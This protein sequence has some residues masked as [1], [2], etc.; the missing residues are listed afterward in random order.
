[1]KIFYPRLR[2]LP[3][4]RAWIGRVDLARRAFS[5][6]A[7]RAVHR[8]RSEGAK[9]LLA[10]LRPSFARPEGDGVC[11]NVRR[12][13][14]L[15]TE[16]RPLRLPFFPKPLVSIVIVIQG[17]G[18]TA[19]ACIEGIANHSAGIPIE[20][21][22]VCD[23]P[24]ESVFSALSL[25]EHLILLGNE[26]GSNYNSSRNR[27]MTAASGDYILFLH[28][29]C[30]AT[31]GWLKSLLEAFDAF[32]NVGA[33]GAKFVSPQGLLQQAG[34]TLGAD[35]T[36]TDLGQ[37][38][39][40][41]R[42]EFNYVKDVDYCS[43]ACILFPRPLL[44]AIGGF[45]EGYASAAEADKDICLAV[46]AQGRRVIY[47]P[48]AEVFH[49]QSTW[50]D[51]PPPNQ[52]AQMLDAGFF[53]NKWQAELHHMPV[54]G[55]SPVQGSHQETMLRILWIEA[56][57]LTPDQDSGSLRTKRLLRL[58][59]QMRC[60]VSFIPDNPDFDWH[61][62]ENLQQMG[63]E[64]LYPPHARS[65]WEHL[66]SLG[67]RYNMIIL[68][69]HYIAI[70]YVDA[71]RRLA[72]KTKI[73]FDTVDLHYLRLNR[74]AELD[75]NRHVRRLAKAAYRDE[76]YTI[77]TCDLTL[78]VSGA[79]KA[80]LAQE[81]PQ[82]HVM[83]LSNVHDPVPWVAPLSGRR[84]ILFVGGFQ[85]PPNLDAIKWY[86]HEIWPQVKRELPE[87]RTLVI[88]SKMPEE[89]RR[90][91]EALGLDMVGYVPDLD[92]YLVPERKPIKFAKTT[93][94]C[95]RQGI[96]WAHSAVI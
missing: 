90:M 35:G 29:D 49:Y 57:L 13:P 68:S 89:F 19:F 83:V 36:G 55:E 32:D 91:G 72:P 27:G 30:L 48:K 62:V 84:N 12:P 42:P 65:V 93:L 25:V 24:K 20:V 77:R 54:R 67:C 87:A 43:G 92:P 51:L 50:P 3:G 79:E 15:D 63:V 94:A 78:V 81:A 82:A 60:Q 14:P 64:V 9:G 1:M 16:I 70:K 73:L 22:A 33:V 10:G 5:L 95:R 21:L 37:G 88:G 76:I 28:D 58:L 69:R 18:G 56:C 6:R 66:A 45:D 96:T 61:Y 34:A 74:Q 41:S 7:E 38:Q 44:I 40:P 86:G 85:H 46:R 53:A 2:F 47:Q 31:E 71:I 75:G 8:F 59:L 39:E 17:E 80:L 23:N 4:I 52:A 11:R 26:G